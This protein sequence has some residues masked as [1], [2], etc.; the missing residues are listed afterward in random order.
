MIKEFFHSFLYEPLYNG[1]VFFIDI[2]PYADVGIAVILL[3]LIVKLVLFPLSIKMVKTQMAVRELEPDLKKIKEKHKNNSQ[4]QAQATMALYKKRGV[5]PF[6][7]ILLL[8]VQIPII[9]ALYWVFF[10]GGLP[11]INVDALYSF[12]PVPSEVNM[13]FLGLI[14]MSM[15]SVILAGAAGLSQYYQMKLSLPP[16]KTRG[17]DP[18]FKDD[19]VRSF[20]MQMRYVLPVI[21]TVI[22]YVISAA[23]ALYWLTSNLFQIGQEM[24]VRRNIKQ[25]ND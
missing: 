21:V 1:L 23:V 18:S 16:M 8:F 11:A 10:K 6:S 14:D 19:L 7:G 3:T 22:S 17:T 25:T 5:N 2:V 20:Q 13:H 24:Y 12:V 15:K 4:E 9:L